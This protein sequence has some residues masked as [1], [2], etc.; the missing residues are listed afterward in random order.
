[1]KILD[2]IIKFISGGFESG[3][4]EGDRH[5]ETVG[6]EEFLLNMKPKI[7]DYI[8]PDSPLSFQEMVA[9]MVPEQVKYDKF[10]LHNQIIGLIAGME[11]FIRD[12]RKYSVLP[13]DRFDRM[14][15]APSGI[16]TEHKIRMIQEQMNV[17]RYRLEYTDYRTTAEA[18]I[19][20]HRLHELY[21][22]AKTMDP[23]GVKR[24]ERM[25]DK[26]MKKANAR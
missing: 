26:R 14:S 22:A 2:K 6:D 4:K 3:G 20:K 7:Q 12:T 21:Q 11:Q 24:Y 19:L 9:I 1:M 18:K 16:T 23:D 10:P 13:A 8:N 25:I 5:D 15:A 17:V